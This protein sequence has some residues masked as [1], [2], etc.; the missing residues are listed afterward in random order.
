MAM[1]ETIHL[2]ATQLREEVLS[3][4]KRELPENLTAEDLIVGE[5]D[6]VPE[7]LTCFLES[8][9]WGDVSHLSEKARENK[10]NNK[11]LAIFSI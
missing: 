9:I 5:V 11:N 3:C 1:R 4:T 8:F 6:S 2:V 10:K 7:L